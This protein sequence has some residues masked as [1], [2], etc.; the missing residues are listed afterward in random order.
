MTSE[1]L[2]LKESGG[3]AWKEGNFQLSIE[4]W[5][6]AIDTTWETETDFLKVVYS[7]RSAA[8]LTLKQNANALLDAEKC[9]K[10]DQ[11]WVRK[12]FI[13]KIMFLSYL[14]VKF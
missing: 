4:E 1:A 10:L 6:K 12:I 2:A 14:I 9:I 5:T 11:K 8:Y 13:L 7:N 3:K